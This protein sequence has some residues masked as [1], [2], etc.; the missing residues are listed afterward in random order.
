MVKAEIKFIREKKQKKKK[1]FVM[2]IEILGEEERG[3]GRERRSGILRLCN[4]HSVDIIHLTHLFG[5]LI[6]I[7]LNSS[8][9]IY[10]NIFSLL[11]F[12]LSFFLLLIV[13]IYEQK[14]RG[15]VEK[16]KK[17]MK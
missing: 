13:F 10:I 6:M 3:K 1:T 11:L 2:R 4:N 12:F 16:E 9:F 17:E 14:I 15:Q 5:S 7:D 8:L